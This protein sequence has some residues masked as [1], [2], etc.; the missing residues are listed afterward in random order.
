MTKIALKKESDGWTDNVKYNDWKKRGNRM[1][2]GKRHMHR[3]IKQWGLFQT[4]GN[5]QEP[6]DTHLRE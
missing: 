6:K 5:H 4:W 1:R 2:K 3:D